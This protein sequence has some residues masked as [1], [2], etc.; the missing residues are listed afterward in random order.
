LTAPIESLGLLGIFLLM[1]PES[2]C[3]PIPSEA[4]LLSAGVGVAHGWFSF[5]L[6]VFAA[7]A[8]NLAGSLI[9]YGLGRRG[10]AAR[11]RGVATSKRLL[12]RWGSLAVFIAR[13]LPLARSFISLPAGVARIP[14]GRFTALTIGGCAL[15]CTGLILAGWMGW[16]AALSDVMPLLGGLTLVGAV[17]LAVRA[18]RVSG[19]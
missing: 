7:T 2:A 1:V 14:L 16:Q 17:A 18:R 6:A 4:T 12:E 10:L 8:G 11:A 9:A 3:L 13:V 15:W 5:P 19:A